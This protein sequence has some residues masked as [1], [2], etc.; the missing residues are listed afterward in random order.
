MLLNKAAALN[1]RHLN[2]MLTPHTAYQ[3]ALDNIPPADEQQDLPLV[4]SRPHLSR[5][6]V[7]DKTQEI[8]QSDFHDFQLSRKL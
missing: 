2:W 7:L 5:Q 6:I 3:G 4:C 1:Q 8:T